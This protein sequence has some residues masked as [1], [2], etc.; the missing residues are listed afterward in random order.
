MLTLML[1][2]LTGDSR[3]AQGFIGVLAMS[4]VRLLE[5][6]PWR[7]TAGVGVDIATR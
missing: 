7:D 5:E 6:H 4:E 2:G 1:L 3:T